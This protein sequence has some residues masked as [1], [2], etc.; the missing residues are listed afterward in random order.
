MEK[1]KPIFQDLLE[2]TFQAKASS[3][4][5]CVPHTLHQEIGKAGRDRQGLA[6][7]GPK[8]QRSPTFL[9]P[10]TSFVEDNFSM[11]GGRGDKV[12]R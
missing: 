5:V 12:S 2:V 6:Y 1:E 8:G 3:Q 7:K 4:A 10:R 11:D 9:A